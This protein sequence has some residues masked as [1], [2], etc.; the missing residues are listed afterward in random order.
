MRLDEQA[1]HC[2]VQ[3]LRKREITKVV[4]TGDINQSVIIV[5]R[6]VLNYKYVVQE[7]SRSHST[8]R[9]EPSTRR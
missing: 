3:I 8:A 2:D 6:E 5:A 9:N 1:Q 7:V 4:D